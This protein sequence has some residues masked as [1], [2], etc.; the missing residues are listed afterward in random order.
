MTKIDV[1][2]DRS[3]TLL[4]PFDDPVFAAYAVKAGIG[5]DDLPEEYDPG[6]VYDNR[7]LPWMAAIPSFRFIPGDDQYHGEI[8]IRVSSGIAYESGHGGPRIEVEGT[9][10]ETVA[11]SMRGRCMTDVV[12]LPSMEKWEI[13]HVELNKSRYR[14]IPALK[15]LQ[16]YAVDS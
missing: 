5:R 15:S 16:L 11:L 12:R 7:D 3:A 14:I 9:I 10:P 4:H 2:Q 1:Q 13:D 8:L 6:E